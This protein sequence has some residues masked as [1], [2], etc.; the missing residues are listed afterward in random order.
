MPDT[1]MRN[2]LKTLAIACCFFSCGGKLPDQIRQA[3]DDLPEA[4]DYNI[5]V[6]PIL[7][8]KC[9]A[10][11]GP[12]EN[13]RHAGLRLDDAEAAFASL[14]E[15]PGKVAIKPKRP[16]KSELVWRILSDDPDF[17][18]PTPESHL[19]LTDRE[20]AIL[21]RWIEEGA[22]YKKHW[23]F[24]PLATV[25]IPVPKNKAWG[26][27]E[28]DRFVLSEME[29]R[30]FHPSPEADKE[31]LLRRISLDITG[32]PPTEEEI[33]AFLA[34][35]SPEA[36]EKQVD[37]LLASPHYG[38]KMALHWLDVAR[39]A[40]THGYTVDRFRDMSLYRD[41]VI[42]AF[43][44]NK[45]FDV[46]VTEQLAGDLL[47]N[48]SKE[49]LLA[50]AFNRIHPQ[51]MEG[52]IVDEEFRVEYVADRTNTLGK[53]FMAL[54]L[55]CARCHD[56][57]YDPVSQK[58]YFE[59]SSFF[60]QVDEAGQISWNDAMPVPTVLWTDDEKENLLRML[61]SDVEREQTKLNQLRRD[62][63]APFATWLSQAGYQRLQAKEIPRGLKAQLDFDALP[64]TNALNRDEKALMESSEVRNQ[65]PVLT[66]G[67]RGNAVKLNGDAWIRMEKS[68][69]FSKS[70]PF[71]VSIWVNIPK[72]R[73]NG[74]IF[75]TGTGA[76]LYNRRG[77]HLYLK[78]NRL[79]LVLAHTAPYNAIIKETLDEVPKDQWI[80]LV[81]T[82]DGSSSAS[83]LH[84]FQNGKQLET[85]VAKDNLYKDILFGKSGQPGIQVGAVW[86]GRGLKNALA[87]DLMVFDRALTTLEVIQLADQQRFKELLSK[88]PTQLSKNEKE[89]LLEYFVH[90]HF[91]P[92][93]QQV[94]RLT[95]SRRR[96]AAEVEPIQE[97]MV[98]QD[99]EPR[100][101]TYLLVRGEYHAHGEEVLPGTP[102][103]VLEM[104][105]SLPKNRLGL[106]KWLLDKKHPLTSRVAVNR[107]WLYLFG[108]GLV[109]TPGDFGNQ[110]EMPS[111]PELL[112]W[113]SLDFMNSGW[114][115][116]AL[117]K[118]ILLSATYR[119]RS[120][121]SE[122]LRERDPENIY[123]AR[124]P[125][126]RLPGE[127]IRD[128]A[129]MASGLLNKKIGGPSVKPYQPEGLWR[130]NGGTYVEAKGD[131][132]Y[133]R[134]LYT[135][136]KRSVPHPTTHIFDAPDRSESVAVRQETNTPLQALVLLND[137]TFVEAAR[138][139]GAEMSTLPETHLAIHKAFRK[140]TGRSATDK[141][142]AI[143]SELREVEYRKF[144]Q[145]P[146][147]AKGW[148]ET[149][150][151]AL[152]NTVDIPTLASH[153]VVASAI[154]NSDAAITKR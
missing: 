150:Y 105:D 102:R 71:S 19:S 135:F 86:R 120:F 89:V 137:P 111:H 97:V 32:L 151:Y 113:L 154:M 11:H 1:L 53:A 119:Q 114:D 28:I 117:H 115:V 109:A 2:I 128:N 131:D 112:D 23:S 52:G 62:A 125:S 145:A 126:G 116:K 152:S 147:K 25:P 65:T 95:E 136:W 82:Y 27:N 3:M 41:W 87:D 36:Y 58:E 140:L 48:P 127:M 10:C 46:F 101:P 85:K 92:F 124:G 99:M 144:Q 43:N 107:F 9:F 59:L 130:V 34:D 21:I 29:I 100:R 35:N 106:A 8:D 122:E 72:E 55:E 91:P 108:R 68:G 38:E 12:D 18:M 17:R 143:L 57:K 31:T 110:G 149:G 69:V 37:R 138:V 4:L 45:P 153:A 94:E 104:P 93:G 121:A 63:G 16:F 54:T 15:S 26:S 56:H 61:E 13:T 20:K 22:V 40:D 51:N 44:S 7:S 14:P 39:Y 134:S 33:D 88:D 50:T 83:G 141:E 75:H 42:E 77:Y 24:I 64:L 81:M 129:L 74:A 98:M 60:N 66:S 47:P 30:G 78:E 84:V 118:K 70:E 73:E 6:K 133:R 103:S 142:L 67:R 76:V 123:L 139:L 79:E 80:N 5:H 49:Q 148:V 132:L 90:N 146:E 96:H